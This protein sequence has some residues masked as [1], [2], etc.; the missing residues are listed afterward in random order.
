MSL[1]RPK[2]IPKIPKTRKK[3]AH[4]SLTAIPVKKPD[5]LEYVCKAF[6][7]YDVINDLNASFQKKGRR[8]FCVG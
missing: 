2:T 1:R 3:K 4:T 7:G 8:V 6:Y 5:K